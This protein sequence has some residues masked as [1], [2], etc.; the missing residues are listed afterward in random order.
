ML[1]ASAGNSSRVQV[2]ARQ[3]NRKQDF[4]SVFNKVQKI[5]RCLISVLGFF[6]L[7]ATQAEAQ[8]SF[9][10]P[11]VLVLGDS[12]LSFGAGVAFIE[13]LKKNGKSCGLDPKWSVG[14]LG[15]RSSSLRAWTARDGGGK[16][17]ICDID[18]KWKVNA[19]SFGVINTSGN[20]YVQI[21]QGAAYQFCK[22]GQSPFEAMFTNGYYNPKLF[23]MAFLGNA[24]ERWA[25]SEADALLDVKA[26]MKEV[27]ANL[28]CIFMTT[29]PGYTSKIN[30]E[31]QRAQDNIEKGFKAAGKRCTFVEG[32]TPQTV[33]ANQGN[34]KK[35][36]L[37]PDGSVKDP[38]HPTEDSARDFL[39]LIKPAL[40]NAIKAE[41][42]G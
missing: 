19:G 41:L 30:D 10:S 16:K 27:P 42:A 6:L 28:P 23:I 22:A 21:G 37:K 24:T 29:A 14:V 2:T 13:F 5:M 1:S 31:R 36:R 12:Q 35:F 4:F 9:T 40:C 18:P 38:Y 20:K 8:E 11:D 39:S 26:A 25:N 32:Y 33:A 7:L 34:A 17:A 15:V 3:S